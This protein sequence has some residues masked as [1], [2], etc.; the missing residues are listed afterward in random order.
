MKLTLLLIFC[1]ACATAFAQDIDCSA[2]PY[3]WASCATHDGGFYAMKGGSQGRKTVLKSNGGDNYDAIVEALTKYD[4][5][6]LDGANG[7]FRISHQMEFNRLSHKTIEGINGACLE[8]EFH[9]T[10]EI[11]HMLDTAHV[12][13][14]SSSSK[15]GVVYNLSNGRRVREECEYQVRQHLINFLNDPDENYQLAGLFSLNGCEDIIMRNLTLR[16]PGAIDVSGKDLLNIC[17]GSKHIWIDHC[18]FLDGIDGNFDINT[19]ADFITVSWCTFTYTERSYIHM[20]TNLIGA[21]DSAEQNGEDC[22][23]VTFHNCTW[24][25]GCDQRMPMVRFGKIHIL[26]C[27]YDC[28]GCLR[29]VNPRRGAE[30]LMENCVWKKGVKNIFQASDDAKAYQFKNCKFE[31]PFTPVD[32]GTV[33]LPY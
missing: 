1:L 6:V 22:M 26:N 10:P 27:T 9:V 23:N 13:Q 28:A 8:T 7:S 17:H 25:R 12:R 19:Y 32:R 18:D 24:G 2:Y 21:S 14:Y 15:P 30:V 5:V 29:T 11:R 31:E 33:V 4:N 20:N 16:G 3:G